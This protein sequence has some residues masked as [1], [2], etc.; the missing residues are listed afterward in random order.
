MA[1]KVNIVQLLCPSR[2][3]VLAAAYEVGKQTFADVKGDI[4]FCIALTR[5]N[6]WCGICGCPELHFED[7]PTRFASI[8][9]AMPYLKK[10]ETENLLA[11]AAIG[12]RF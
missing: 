11:R 3:C 9:E 8:E 7:A 10:I 2:H 12:G 4:H 6:P 5:V 1:G